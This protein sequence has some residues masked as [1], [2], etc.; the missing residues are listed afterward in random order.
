MFQLPAPDNDK[1]F[2]EMV[3][4][5]S[6]SFLKDNTFELYARR[7]QKQHGIDGHNLN[8]EIVFQCKKKALH[9]VNDSELVEELKKE[10]KEE[11]EQ[12]CKSPFKDNIKCYYFATTFKNDG[13]LQNY[14]MELS[15]K[16]KFKV[17]YWGWDSITEKLQADRKLLQSYYPA[18]I[19]DNDR[20]ENLEQV[21]KSVL[22]I[23]L[24]AI[25]GWNRSCNKFSINCFIKLQINRE[26][27]DQN[28]TSSDTVT[29]DE[30]CKELVDNKRC[31]LVASPGGGKTTT[32]LQIATKL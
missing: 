17:T 15:G 4:D 1:V 16:L 5:V 21:K 31:V 18:L 6:R 8:F 3:I 9:G 26:N 10:M 24:K 23:V 28:H 14:A 19:I 27:E 11:V 29:H 13:N 7:G 20:D 25:E 30:I 32:L 22:P 2:E 12:A